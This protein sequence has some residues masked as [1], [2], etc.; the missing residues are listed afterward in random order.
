MTLP[1]P[2]LKSKRTLLE[3]ALEVSTIEAGAY[4]ASLSL[5]IRWYNYEDLK[6]ISDLRRTTT[7]IGY[8]PIHLLVLLATDAA[9]IELAA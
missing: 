9:D 4:F 6:K 7:V 5:G 8:L 2:S 3:S 1:R